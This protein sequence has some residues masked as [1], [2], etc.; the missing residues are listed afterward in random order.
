[1]TSK[2]SYAGGKEQTRE[3][4]LAYKERKS[5]KELYQKLKQI[6]KKKR[7]SKFFTRWLVDNNYLFLDKSLNN[8][9]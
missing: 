4:E 6:T 3:F 2:E 7:V 9:Q 5:F 8:K 1:M